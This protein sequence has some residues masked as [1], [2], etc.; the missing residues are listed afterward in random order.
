[1]NRFTSLSAILLAV[2]LATGVQAQTMSAADARTAK[3]RI[4]TEYKTANDV[5]KSLADN[6]K[7]VCVAEAK[8]R[9]KVAEAELDYNRS[10]KSGDMEKWNVARADA[11]YDVAK[12]KCDDRSGNVKDL[13]VQEAKAAHTKAKADAKAGKKTAEARQDA[14]E[15]KREADWKVAKERCDQL[16]GDA[17]STCLDSAKARLGKS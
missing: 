17:K 5:C 8:G 7:D 6:A 14:A 13:C 10:G 3:E 11:A 1:M 4:E 2:G 15:D 16:A 9:R 12:E